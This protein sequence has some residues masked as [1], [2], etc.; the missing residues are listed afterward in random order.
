MATADARIRA[1]AA[2]EIG[3]GA[4]AECAALVQR[5]RSMPARVTWVRPENF[6]LTVRFLGDVTPDQIA[7]YAKI[8]RPEF[9]RLPAFEAW[10]RGVG[11]FPHPRWP[12]VIWTGFESAESDATAIQSIAERAACAIGLAAETRPYAPHVTLGRVRKESQKG[13][14]FT[15]LTEVNPFTTDAFTVEAVSL[16]S[17]ELTPHGAQYTR[18]HR[19]TLDG[20]RISSASRDI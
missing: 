7:A 18:L 6:H 12:T 11:V 4:R 3:E 15:R 13:G 10:L 19:L 5:M 14:V 2:I 20:T 1:F 16:F 17:S 9:S 8:L